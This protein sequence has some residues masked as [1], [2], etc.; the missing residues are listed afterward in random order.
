MILIRFTFLIA[1]FCYIIPL[2]AQLFEGKILYEIETG[3]DLDARAQMM[4]PKKSAYYVKGNKSRMEA[5]LPMGM[6]N[7]TITDLEGKKTTNLLNFLGNKYAIEEPLNEEYGVETKNYKVLN[8]SETKTIAG[9]LCKRVQLSYID[10]STGE[11][12]N[13]DVWFTDE[14]NTNSRL[15]E[16]RFA[17]LKGTLME[18]SITQEGLTMKLTAKEVIPQEV[19][20]KMFD[21][22]TDYQRTTRE[23]LMQKYGGR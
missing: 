4:M 7:I 5:E 23:E 6:S 21:I 20:D 12:R 8:T 3:K 19:A 10:T 9:Y 2:K 15:I 1:I 11:E 18:F 13:A 16:Q 22:P 17:Q 14:I